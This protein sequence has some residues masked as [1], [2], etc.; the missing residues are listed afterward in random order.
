LTD[1]S[2]M[3]RI[4]S[5]SSS[6]TEFESPQ[7]YHMPWKTKKDV[8]EYHLQRYHRLRQRIVAYLG[9]KCVVCGCADNLEVH[10]R[11]PK[12]KSFNVSNN[13][14]RPWAILEHEL[15]K[16]ELRCRNHHIEFH[17]TA[18][19]GTPSMYTNR[20]CRC[21]ACREANRI[22]CRPYRKKYNEKQRARRQVDKG[23]AL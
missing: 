16:C 5:L 9:G 6:G 8:A 2:S 12:E 4:L 20:K 1:L 18:V 14:G 19:H 3:G 7:V 11:N 22:A 15:A 23:T 17:A 10:H 21:D 13:W